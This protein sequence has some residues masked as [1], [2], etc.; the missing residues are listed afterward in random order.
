MSFALALVAAAL[1]SGQSTPDANAV[2]ER[3]L[4]AVEHDS[5]AV[6]E[7]RWTRTLAAHP[8]NREALL[9]LATLARLTYRLERADSLASRLVGD[10]DRGAT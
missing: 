1:V 7:A 6:V 2:V 10:R 4:R 3:A 5:V 8:A 9:G